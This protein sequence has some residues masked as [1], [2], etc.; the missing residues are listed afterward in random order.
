MIDG[1][2]DVLAIVGAVGAGLVGGVFYAFS[3]FVMQALGRLPTRSAVA[4]MH[5]INIEAPKPGL[6]IAFLGTAVVAI[7]LSI[8]AFSRLGEQAA[9][10]QLV[11]GALYLLG[12]VLT[13]VYHVPR[14]DALGRLEPDSE[15]AAK[16]WDGYVRGWTRWN[17]VRMLTSLSASVVLILS[18]LVV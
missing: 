10:Y 16:A 17:H 8:S 13:A 2:S 15:A 11:G 18:L 14:N 4:A 12:V 3:T 1:Y 9:T 7:A 6:M 5:A